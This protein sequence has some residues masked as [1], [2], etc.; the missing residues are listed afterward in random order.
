[1]Y[2]ATDR[3]KRHGSRRGQVEGKADL[4]QRV[5]DSRGLCGEDDQTVKMVQL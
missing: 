2:G 1:M 4:L 5:G 3:Q